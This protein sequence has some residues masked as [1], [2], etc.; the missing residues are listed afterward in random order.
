MTLDDLRD[1][2]NIS[3]YRYVVPCGGGAGWQA[4]R[5]G[6]GR[7]DGW[8]G[9]MRATPAA[10]AQDYCDYVNGNAIDAPLPLRKAGHSVR[11]TRREVPQEVHEARAVIRKH[12]EATETPGGY[13]YLI[14]EG[15]KRCMFVKI[16]ES[17][18]DPS[19]RLPEL[20]TGNPR[21]LVL[22]GSIE[23]DDRKALESKLHQRFIKHNVLQEWF[24]NRPE[25]RKAFNV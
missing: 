18:D 23:T 12:K 19:A 13:V 4:S 7:P 10:A 20:Q 8:R 22:L 16:G 21:K 14:G 1:P 2:S 11:R 25:I 3:G 24:V 15:G 5:N 9:P 17:R 6:G